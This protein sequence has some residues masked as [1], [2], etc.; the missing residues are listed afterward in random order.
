MVSNESI[1]ACIVL[2][3]DDICSVKAGVQFKDFLASIGNSG[4]SSNKTA[5][6]PRAAGDILM[7]D[8]SRAHEEIVLV[9]E[10]AKKHGLS[11]EQ[12]LQAWRNHIGLVLRLERN[13]GLVDHKTIGFSDDG[14]VIE[15]TARVK[16]FGFLIFHANTPPSERTLRELGFERRR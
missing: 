6:V 1:C 10:R 9:M 8:K 14:K 11:E 5:L 7:Q 4:I 15:L 2:S 12:I 3:K 16:K 13:D